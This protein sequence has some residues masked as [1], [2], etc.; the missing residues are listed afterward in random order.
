VLRLGSLSRQTTFSGAASNVA[1]LGEDQI[2]TWS[3]VVVAT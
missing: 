2:P 3:P 1:R